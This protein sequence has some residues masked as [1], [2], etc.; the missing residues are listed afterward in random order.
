MRRLCAEAGV[1]PFGFH[2]IR[3]LSAVIL[4]RSGYQVAV[5]QRILRHEA[6]TTTE[7]YLRALSL[8]VDGLRSAVQTFEGRGPGKVLKMEMAPRKATSGGHFAPRVCPQGA[9]EGVD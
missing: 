8:D 6:P 5:I 2:A 3:H 9:S 4:Y 7:R 1:E